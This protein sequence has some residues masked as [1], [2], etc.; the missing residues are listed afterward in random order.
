[1][2]GSG[3]CVCKPTCMQPI[4]GGATKKLCVYLL[5]P[6]RLAAD[7]VCRRVHKVFVL[8]GDT[9]VLV[10]QVNGGFVGGHLKAVRRFDG[11]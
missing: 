1:M 5:F 11:N 7:F 8:V 6:H 10:A 4:D 2:M 3:K 9:F